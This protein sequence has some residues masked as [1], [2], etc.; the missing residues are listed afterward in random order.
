M[1]HHRVLG[2]VDSFVPADL[3]WTVDAPGSRVPSI[4]GASSLFSVEEGSVMFCREAAVIGLAI[5]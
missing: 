1:S 3:D 4:C 5:F 2:V